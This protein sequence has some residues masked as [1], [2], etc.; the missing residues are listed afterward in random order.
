[1][2]ESNPKKRITIDEILNH[3][4]FGEIRS[5]ND[6]ELE[7]Y[8]EVIKLKEE[9]QRRKLIVDEKVKDEIKENIEKSNKEYEAN[10]T[11]K[12]ISDNA[13]DTFLLYFS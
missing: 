12:A 2:V 11:I 13:N 9:F 7:I 4:W 3:K 5:M 10:K 8:E 1:M 6:K